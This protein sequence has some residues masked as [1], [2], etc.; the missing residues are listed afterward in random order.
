MLLD[1]HNGIIAL[2]SI[3]GAAGK[4][5]FQFPANINGVPL[6]P[7]PQGIAAIRNQL[8]LSSICDSVSV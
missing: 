4:T 8:Q 3:R 1:P 2:S 7:V 5:I 6:I